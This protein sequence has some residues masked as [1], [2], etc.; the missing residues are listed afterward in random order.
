VSAETLKLYSAQLSEYLE[1]DVRSVCREIAH[2]PRK[3]GETAF[4]ELGKIIWQ[5]QQIVDERRR[6]LCSQAER[7]RYEGWFWQWVTEQVEDTGKS[8]QEI[9]DSVKVSG[10][11]GRKARN[12]A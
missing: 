11:T 12:G 10:Y 5:L 7:D 9:L 4:P 8:E 6:E 3:E 2:A 1:D